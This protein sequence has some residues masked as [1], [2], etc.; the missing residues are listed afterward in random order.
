MKVVANIVVIILNYV[1]SKLFIFK[2]KEKTEDKIE[3]K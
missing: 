3:E 2:S 1:F